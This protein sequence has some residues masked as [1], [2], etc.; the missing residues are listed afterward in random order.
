ML[1]PGEAHPL[2]NTLGYVRFGTVPA[3]TTFFFPMCIYDDLLTFADSSSGSHIVMLN[4]KTG[5][6]VAKIAS[7]SLRVTRGMD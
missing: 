4:W 1:S 2:T 6:Q 5:D 7:R 3:N